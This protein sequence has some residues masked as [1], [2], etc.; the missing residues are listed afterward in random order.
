MSIFEAALSAKS[1]ASKYPSVWPVIGAKGIVFGNSAG[2][3]DDVRALQ[4]IGT[5]SRIARNAAIFSQGDSTDHAYKMVSG[6]VRLCKHMSGGRRHI[7]QFLYP[8]DFFSVMEND[9]HSF[10]AEAVTDVVLTCY[11]QGRLAALSEERPS[12]GRRFFRLLTERLCEM[13]NHLTVLGRQTAKERVIS[14]LLSLLDHDGLDLDEDNL[15]EVPMNRQDIADYLGLTNE[16][17][18]RVVS[19]LKRAGLLEIPNNHQFVLTDIDA[20]QAVVD[21]EEDDD[22]EPNRKAA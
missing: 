2:V 13:E 18:C 16:T 11:P 3:D 4:K 12:L 10:T 21:G 1:P 22:W 17:V 19:E 6:V 15:V 8:G 7:A 14:F 5:K 9:C 20:L